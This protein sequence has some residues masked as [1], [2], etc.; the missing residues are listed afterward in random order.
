M[1]T[2]CNL[3]SSCTY[4]DI[5]MRTLTT[6][7]LFVGVSGLCVAQSD[8]SLP[9]L[10]TAKQTDVDQQ[11]I[12]RIKQNYLPIQYGVFYSQATSRGSL[13]YAYDSL[14]VP[15]VGYGIALNAG[16]YC[17]PFPLVIGAE[18]AVHFYGTRER[19]YNSG[20]D[21]VTNSSQN[22]AVP[23]LAFARIQPNLFT[24]I[25]PYVEIAGGT[26]IY[27]SVL[28]ATKVQGGEDVQSTVETRVSANWTYEVGA[29]IAFKVLDIITL[30]NSLQRTLVDFRMRYAWGTNVQVSLVDPTQDQSYLVRSISVSTPEQI[31]LQLGVTMQL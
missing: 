11:M 17:E 24:W 3:L 23:L 6:I 1:V 7:L 31:T 14:G 26:T 16:Y 28:S 19:S 20:K 18:F 12:D 13:R 15:N 22:I 4:P 25:F 10:T 30:P 21:R 27:S 9:L 5:A 29:G 2:L 8:T